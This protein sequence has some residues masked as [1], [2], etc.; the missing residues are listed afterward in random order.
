MGLDLYP[1]QV[2]TSGVFTGPVGGTT[3]TFS[4]AVSVGSLATSGTV[5]AGSVNAT[6]AVAGGSAAF[7]GAVT[8]HGTA[9][10]PRVASGVVSLSVSGG[11]YGA[12][13]VSFPAGRF[14][15]PPLGFACIQNAVTGAQRLV[16]RALNITTTGMTVEGFTGDGVGPTTAGVEVAW[17]AVQ[18]GELSAGG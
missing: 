17:L 1:P 8:H 9:P 14:T 6:G 13:A 18:V 4:G 16:P 3:G 2:G 15:I 5:A 12:M 11:T 10:T 7:T